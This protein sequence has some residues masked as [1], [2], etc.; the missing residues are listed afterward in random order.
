MVNID[1]DCSKFGNFFWAYD[2]NVVIRSNRLAE[3]V[4]RTRTNPYFPWENKTE[5]ISLVLR[6]VLKNDQNRSKLLEFSQF[7]VGMRPRSGYQIK[8]M[9]L[10]YSKDEL[11]IFSSKTC[12]VCHINSYS[13]IITNGTLASPP[14]LSEVL[15][16]TSESN[17]WYKT[18]QKTEDFSRTNCTDPTVPEWLQG[19]PR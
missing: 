19:S 17:Q 8:P 7:S 4:E 3:R 6:M 13:A 1:R 9:R 12:I 5:A 16:V 18:G 11:T 15:K 14:S 2:P 10:G